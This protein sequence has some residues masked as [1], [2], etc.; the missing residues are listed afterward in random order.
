MRWNR[1]ASTVSHVTSLGWSGAKEAADLV[2]NSLDE[3]GHYGSD[4]EDRGSPRVYAGRPHGHRWCLSEQRGNQSLCS[5]LV[6]QVRHGE[7]AS[8]RML[9]AEDVDLPSYQAVHQQLLAT[10]RPARHP[11][12]EFE[13]NRSRRRTRTRAG[14]PVC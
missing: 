3:N 9:D 7:R 12:V 8:S 13:L 2:L 14:S 10:L 6:Y 1:Y 11:W 5:W 4:L